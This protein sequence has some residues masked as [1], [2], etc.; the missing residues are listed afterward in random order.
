MILKCTQTKPR[1]RT[2]KAILKNKNKK[3][4]ILI[5]P[6]IWNYYKAIIIETIIIKPMCHWARDIAKRNRRVYK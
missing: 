1:F 2:G 5:T 3:V 6:D 4:V